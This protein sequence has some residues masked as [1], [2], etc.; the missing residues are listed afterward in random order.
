MAIEEVGVRLRARDDGFGRNVRQA[1]QSVERLG[2]AADRTGDKLS[3][4][5]RLASSAVSGGVGLIGSAAR[6]AAVGVAALTAGAAA[7]SYSLVTLASDAAETESK[8][9]T[10]FGTGGGDQVSAWIRDI[11]SNV[12]IATDEL[13]SAA[14]TFGVFG[15]AVGVPGQELARFSTDLAAAGLDLA[16]FSN[17]SPE[18]VFLAL[19]SGLAGESEPLRQFGIFLSDASLNAFAAAEGIGKTTAE[20]TEQEK[21]LLRQRFILSN[22]GA[23]EGDLERTAGGLA[24]QQR[25]L[26]GVFRDLRVELGEALMPAAQRLL[27]VLTDGLQDA[28]D[29][30]RDNLPDIQERVG[31][32]A[33]DLVRLYRTIRNG[34]VDT[35]G[36][37]TQMGD[38]FGSGLGGF[39]G[40]AIQGFRDLEVAV[41]DVGTRQGS[42]QTV[43]SMFGPDAGDILDRVF[44]AGADI[45]TVFDESLVPAWNDAVESLGP[46]AG[47]TGRAFAEMLGWAADNAEALEPWFKAIFVTYLTSSVVSRVAG[48]AT[49]TRNLAVA[50]GLLGVN[51][52][53]AATGAGGGLLA[54]LFGGAALTAGGTLAVA[55]AGVAAAGTAV[56]AAGTGQVPG[57]EYDGAGTD[58][59]THLDGLSGVVGGQVAGGGL[60]GQQGPTPASVG[61]DSWNRSRPAAPVTVNVTNNITGVGSAGDL[62]PILRRNERAVVEAVQRGL[63]RSRA[64]D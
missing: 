2:R 19:R 10:V 11:Q 33:D 47:A 59:D 14:S 1:E 6:G 48:L 22:L 57:L 41:A 16:S 26:V 38:V 13:Q 54:R 5:G 63:D 8:F 51:S 32:W 60:A 56:Y 64:R 49:A 58:L 37:I 44:E 31:G 45:A 39:L 46:L 23:A 62:T 18:D 29:G 27:P 35:T 7:A 55:G 43:E 50:T 53:A 36:F 40:E 4:L 9:N 52:T 20:M 42:I 25:G 15:Q 34:R 28:L 3:G 24:N 30:I 61:S 12:H 17:A 21:V